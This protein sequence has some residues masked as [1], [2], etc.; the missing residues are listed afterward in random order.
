[1]GNTLPWKLPSDLRSFKT[2][3]Q[4][5]VVI[6]GRKTYESI[7]NKPLP[8]RHNVV[9]SSNSATEYPEGV[10]LCP[11]PK[12]AIKASRMLCMTH[13]VSDIFVIGGSTIYQAFMK[14][15][16]RMILTTLEDKV[17]GDIFFPQW[18]DVFWEVKKTTDC[19]D[20][21]GYI[22]NKPETKGLRY[23]IEEYERIL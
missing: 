5:N 17:E 18:K 16:D 3:T 22:L 9:I 20:P 15:A 7:G 4:N 2:L 13:N 1:M 12:E 19:Y 14:R 21:E 23:K 6:M 11:D 8:H 10:I